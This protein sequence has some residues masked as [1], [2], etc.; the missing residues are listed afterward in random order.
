M[1]NPIT[2]ILFFVGLCVG[3]MVI[4]RVIRL[5]LE[6]KNQNE[7]LEIFN[8]VVDGAGVALDGIGEAMYGL[9]IKE[10]KEEEKEEDNSN[11]TVVLQNDQTYNP[12]RNS[13]SKTIVLQGDQKYNPFRIQ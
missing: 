7:A 11:E 2:P 4:V 1:N 3:V 5:I 12:Y 8:G 9:D 10:S 13:Q 6:S